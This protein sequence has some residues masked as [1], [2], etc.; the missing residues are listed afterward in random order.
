MR[1]G[2]GREKINLSRCFYLLLFDVYR[3]CS[4]KTTDREK[5]WMQLSSPQQTILSITSLRRPQVLVVEARCQRMRR[6]WMAW[7]RV[8]GERL[9][10][11]AWQEVWGALS[12]SMS[13]TQQVLRQTLQCQPHP[14][15]S[16]SKVIERERE[17]ER[18]IMSWSLC[19]R[20]HCTKNVVNFLNPIKL[21][22][23]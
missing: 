23:L 10:M 2:S 8:W 1:K 4:C 20:T 19:I 18:E 14:L 13:A 6:C 11:A 21:I 15:V 12:H 17:R 5:S 22:N 9:W 16:L 7:Q 3:V